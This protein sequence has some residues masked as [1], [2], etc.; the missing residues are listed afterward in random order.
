MNKDQ[1]LQ[2]WFKNTFTISNKAQ[3]T[4]QICIFNSGSTNEQTPA[5]IFLCCLSALTNIK[6]TLCTLLKIK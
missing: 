2:S 5:E 4:L 1:I 6:D 3:V